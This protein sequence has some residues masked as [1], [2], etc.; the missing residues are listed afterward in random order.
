MTLA[1][2][3]GKQVVE[4]NDS[5][6]GCSKNAWAAPFWRRGSGTGTLIWPYAGAAALLMLV[7]SIFY[8]PRTLLLAV[9]CVGSSVLT[10]AVCGRLWH[11]QPGGMTHS[12]AIGLIVGLMLPASAPWFVAASGAAIAVAAGKWILGGLGHYPWNPPVLA[13]MVLCLLWPEYVMPQRWPLLSQEHVLIGNGLQMGPLA[14]GEAPLDWQTTEAPDD[15]IGLAAV[16]ADAT[17]GQTAE[18]DDSSTALTLDTA[19]RDV[20]PSWQD[21]L[22]GAVAGPIG[23]GSTLVLIL[24]GLG[25]IWRGYLR[26]P[27]PI[28]VLTGALAAAAILPV[29]PAGWWPIGYRAGGSPV[30]LIWV[31]YQVLL[32]PTLFTAVMLAGETVT[33]PIGNRGQFVYGLGVGVLTVSLRWWPTATLSGCWA[34][35]AM[36]TLVPGIDWLDRRWRL[37]VGR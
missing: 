35:L 29:A 25:L 31:G 8:G 3:E 2:S 13:L 24:V 26:W 36:N 17:L 28:A 33:S 14:K 37:V 12:L 9:M 15:T 1:A 32:G 21:M 30:G 6:A 11:R 27:I 23:E 22:I 16:R 5:L 4:V 10:E 19:V 7:G 20:L 34:V 18:Q